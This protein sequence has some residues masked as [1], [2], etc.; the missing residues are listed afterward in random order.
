M[1]IWRPLT[2]DHFHFET[3]TKRDSELY[4]YKQEYWHM[5]LVMMPSI[6]L[7]QS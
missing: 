4:K 1:A 7:A 6:G 3:T 5:V 2:I